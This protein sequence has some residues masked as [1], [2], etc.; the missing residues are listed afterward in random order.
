MQDRRDRRQCVL[1]LELEA[2][3]HIS[4]QGPCKGVLT[5]ELLLG[6]TRSNAATFLAAAGTE[7][8]LADQHREDLLSML[9]HI[10]TLKF[11]KRRPG[12]CLGGRLIVV[13]VLTVGPLVHS[14]PTGAPLA[15]R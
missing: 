6:D 3:H 14:L 8:H 1:L 12:L 10:T 13:A 2:A 5:D 11:L 15:R 7:A 4:K 9:G